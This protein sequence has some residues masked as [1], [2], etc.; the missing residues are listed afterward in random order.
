MFTHTVYS[1]LHSYRTFR[2]S[3][4]TEYKV[5]WDDWDTWNFE[6]FRAWF[7]ECLHRKIDRDDTRSGRKHTDQYQRDLQWDRDRI[8][9]YLF[10]RLRSTGST[11]LLRTPELRKRYPHINCQRA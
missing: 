8:H 11:G 10:R 9:D 6:R 1:L 4:N 3:P 5:P 7:L 2:T